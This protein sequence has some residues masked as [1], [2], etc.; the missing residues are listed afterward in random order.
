[1]TKGT[2]ILIILILYMLFNLVLGIWMSK[3][4]AKQNA[5]GGFL[6][7]YFMGGRSMGGVVLAMTLIATYTSASS[8]LG[9]PG[10]ASSWGLTQSWVAAIQIGTAFLT[11]GVVGKK[12][13]LISRRIKAVTV[14]DYLRARYKSPAVVIMCSV[15]LVIFFI[16]QMVAQFIGG[17]TLI[18]TVTGLPYALYT[19]FHSCSICSIT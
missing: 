10:L 6:Q 8:F 16:T 2:G 3:K 18:Q 19:R 14:S 7:N 4:S 11:L 5:E 1:M 9:G 12:L 15:A 13:G 17:A